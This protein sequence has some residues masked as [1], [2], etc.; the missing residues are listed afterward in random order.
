MHYLVSGG[1]GFIGSN[2]CRFLLSQGN[3]ITILDDLSTATTS[4]FDDLLDNPDVSFHNVSVVDLDIS[5]Y[6]TDYSKNFCNLK[7]DG[8]FNL[9]CAESPS[10]YQL[11]PEKTILTNVLGTLNMLKIAFSF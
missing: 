9:A 2:L 7:P 8:I 10:K 5:K 1:A 6:T 4:T 11:D 3:S